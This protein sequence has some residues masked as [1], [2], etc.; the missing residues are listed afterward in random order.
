MLKSYQY[1]NLCVGWIPSEGT[2]AGGRYKIFKTYQE[3]EVA[4]HKV[5]IPSYPSLDKMISAA[6]IR[7]G[8][9]RYEKSRRGR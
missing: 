3:Y 1:N 6:G 9:C 8:R 5:M 2:V 7:G 4:Y